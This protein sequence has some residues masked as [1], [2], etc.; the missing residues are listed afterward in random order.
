M[1]ILF[2]ANQFVRW[3]LPTMPKPS[4][5]R[6]HLDAT[7]LNCDNAIHRGLPNFG[8][9]MTMLLESPVRLRPMTIGSINI[10]TPLTLAPM[11]GQTNHAF[12]AL[13]REIGDCGFV[14]TELLSSQAIHFKN[15]KTLNMFDWSTS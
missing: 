10:E 15:A 2:K 12:R 6:T 13:C 1:R 4:R 7:A 5:A 11:A 14:C 9:F 8:V 3:Q